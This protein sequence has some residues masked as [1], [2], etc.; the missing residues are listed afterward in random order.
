MAPVRNYSNWNQRSSDEQEQ[1]E[2]YQKFFFICEGQN[3]EVY[4]F[5]KIIDLRK[6]LDI[7][8]LID[9]CLLEKT[10][11]HKSFS[12]PKSLLDFA[13][14]QKSNPELSFDAER[15]QMVV[16]FDADVFRKKQVQYM[17]LLE[18]ARRYNDIVAVTNPAFELF[19]LLHYENA[20]EEDICP[21]TTEILENQ[22]KGK[23]RF[24]EW[25]F[26]KKS[27]MNSKGNPA[28]G[29]LAEHVDIAIVQE[30]KLNQDVEQCMGNLTCNVGKV[31][32]DIRK[33]KAPITG[34]SPHNSSEDV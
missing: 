10:G 12:H 20:Y 25:L 34:S 15:D 29:N 14:E 11:E 2:P 16:V 17:E 9:I 8:P 30:Q 26:W 19:L 24:A 5:K 13:E 31:I 1:V 22:K 27:G 28:V 33:I 6:Q 21:N 7:H 32:D 18:R 23:K 4:Y 3:T